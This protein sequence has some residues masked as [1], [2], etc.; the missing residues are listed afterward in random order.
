MVATIAP[1]TPPAPTPA[2]TPAP[3]PP[4]ATVQ[5]KVPG[6]GDG[7]D[8]Q[9]SKSNVPSDGSTTATTT[10]VAAASGDSGDGKGMG[11]GVVAIIVILIILA[12]IGIGFLYKQQRGMEGSAE[13]YETPVHQIET[14]NPV[15][16]GGPGNDVNRE[17]PAYSSAGILGGGHGTLHNG[18]YGDIGP[19]VTATTGGNRRLSG[20]RLAGNAV[21]DE[22]SASAAS[23][24]SRG[25]A[26][27]NACYDDVSYET[28]QQGGP[29]YM[30]TPTYDVAVAGGGGGGGGASTAKP[31]MRGGALSNSM[32]MSDSA[33][34][35]R[36]GALQNSGLYQEAAAAPPRASLAQN[37]TYQTVA[38]GG[39][40][41]EGEYLS[42]S[43]ASLR[44]H[45]VQLSPVLIPE[46][47]YASG[48]GG[49][50]AFFPPMPIDSLMVS[51]SSIQSFRESSHALGGSDA[52]I[53]SRARK[54]STGSTGRSVSSV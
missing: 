34:P 21:Y 30:E 31:S 8:S 3:A 37:A 17:N 48:G 41:G 47:T 26:L 54:L 1:T 23:V 19:A 40:G 44:R 13:I 50:Q 45:S 18:L 15:Y 38:P 25:G 20:A 42:T 46:E 36:G 27:G 5:P 49:E 9:E 52:S 11:S 32:Y 53:G 29:V 12:L 33:T 2:P 4:A 43:S 14:E 39:A 6:D 35:A 7:G 22:L 28:A 51:N 24:A 10:P 16:A